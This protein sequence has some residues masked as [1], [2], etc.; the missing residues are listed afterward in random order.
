MINDIKNYDLKFK[1]MDMNDKAT[2]QS[3]LHFCGIPSM[4][5]S[6]MRHEIA[7]VILKKFL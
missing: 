1:A 2:L 7:D 5:Y 6:V 3:F 4:H